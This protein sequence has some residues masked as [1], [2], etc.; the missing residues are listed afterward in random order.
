MLKMLIGAAQG[1]PPAAGLG[2][3]PAWQLLPFLLSP[4][5]SSRLLFGGFSSLLF[6]CG[7]QT[8]T[9]CHCQLLSCLAESKSVCCAGGW[10]SEQE[11]EHAAAAV[12]H[13]PGL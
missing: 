13:E 12:P 10:L 3:K 11:R 7:R 5:L 8:D 1:K 2:Q 9:W 4:C 6:A